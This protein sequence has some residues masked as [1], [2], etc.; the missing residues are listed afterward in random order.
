[1]V[2]FFLQYAL[3][4]TIASLLSV[5]CFSS[6]ISHTFRYAPNGV[7]VSPEFF[8]DEKNRDQVFTMRN[9]PGEGDC[10]FLAV[11]LAA[12]ASMGL[13]GNDTLLRAISRETREVVAQVLES[14]GNL[15]IAD[16]RICPASDL[17]KSAANG[18]GLDSKQ[19][20]E[21]LRKEGIN[22]GIQGGGPELT[23]LANVLRRPISIYELY[24]DKENKESTESTSNYQQIECKGTFGND[25]FS[26]PSYAIPDAAVLSVSTWRIKQNSGPTHASCTHSQM[27]PCQT[28]SYRG[29]NQVHIAGIYTFLF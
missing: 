17:L 8:V 27:S 5:E 20:L 24:H 12:A 4:V 3:F 1:M 9:V 29:C 22:G 25:L 26:D 2:S 11:A 19:Y 18:E 15:Y 23:V 13:G 10:M 21:L 6:R 16:D 28:L 7:C 14:S